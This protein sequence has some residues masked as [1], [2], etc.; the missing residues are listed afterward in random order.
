[1]AVQYEAITH[2]PIEVD[3]SP[4]PPVTQIKEV[5]TTG[6]S[7]TTEEEPSEDREPEPQPPETEGRERKWRSLERN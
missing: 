5:T 2:I 6:D 7:P 4:W 1:M 3:C